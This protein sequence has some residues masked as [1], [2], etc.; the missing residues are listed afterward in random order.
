MHNKE[1]EKRKGHDKKRENGS[2]KRKIRIGI[3]GLR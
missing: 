3:E 2:A 1:K